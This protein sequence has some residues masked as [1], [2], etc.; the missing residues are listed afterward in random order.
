[1][2]HLEHLF[3]TFMEIP[4]TAHKPLRANTSVF[5]ISAKMNEWFRQSLRNVTK[6]PPSAMAGSPPFD[7]IALFTG[8]G[9]FLFPDV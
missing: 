7:D 2:I 1:M 4:F 5:E 6:I 9:R 3:L 8:N